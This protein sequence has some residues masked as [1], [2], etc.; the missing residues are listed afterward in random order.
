MVHICEFTADLIHN[1]K[2]KLDPKP[3]RPHRSSPYHDSCNP[4]RAMGLFE[5]P[6]YILNNACNHFYEM[7]ED[8]IREKT[9]CCGAGR[10]WEMTKTWRCG[11]GAV[12]RGPWPSGKS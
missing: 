5:E 4:A 6:R 11:C 3:Q 1:G 2:L 8:T 10:V 9:F 7:A 12:C